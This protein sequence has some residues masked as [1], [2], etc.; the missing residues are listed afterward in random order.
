MGYSV[1]VAHTGPEGLEMALAG[2]FD[3]IILD[4]MLPRLDGFEVLKALRAESNVPVIMPHRIGRRSRPDCR[5]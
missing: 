4:V 5:T 2:N 1:S 3:A